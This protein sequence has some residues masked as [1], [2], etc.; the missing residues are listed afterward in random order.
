MT[1][2]AMMS[3]WRERFLDKPA[4][5]AIEALVAVCA[6]APPQAAT[7]TYAIGDIHGRVDL[8]IALLAA[9]RGAHPAHCVCKLVFL[10]DLVDRGP[11]SAKTVAMVRALEE[12]APP[13]AVSCLRGNHEQLMVDWF[14]KGDDLW[15]ANGGLATID[16]F[17]LEDGGDEI[18]ADAVEWMGRAP[19]W[20]EDRLRVYVHAG[21]RPGS[22][23]DRQSD[24]DRL[25]I[26]EEFLVGDHDFGK[27]VIHG[28][29]PSLNGPDRRPFR[30]NIDTGAVYGGALTA[31][32]LDD[33]TPA[34][35]GFLQIPA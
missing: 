5:D 9:I 17:G 26:R 1:R 25:W 29:T 33:A 6:T 4:S 7:R 22:P 11:H 2:R 34:P 16:S 10:G 23:Y 20:R 13:S 18:F 35:V 27:H 24:H 21:L 30:T 32:V 8:L 31:A 15:L 12:E 14:R 3:S 19:T 28:H